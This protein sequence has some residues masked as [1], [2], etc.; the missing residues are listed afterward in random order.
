MAR[1]GSASKSANSIARLLHAGTNEHYEDAALYDFEY[2]DQREDVGWYRDR[3]RESSSQHPILELGAG[4]GRITIPL[5]EDGHAI[6]AVDRKKSMLARLRAKAS[7]PATDR[8][9]IIEA[10]ICD[11]PFDDHSMGMVIA[12]FNVMMHLYGWDQLLRCFEEVAR[13]L[14]PGGMF[15]FDVLLPD[16]EWLL[17]DPEFHH[18]RTRFIHPETKRPMVYSTNHTYDHETQVSHIRIHYHDAVGR[19]ARVRP[20]V[21]PRKTVHLAHRQIWPEELRCLLHLSGLQLDSLEGDF[22]G[23]RLTKNAESQVVVAHQPTAKRDKYTRL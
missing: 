12:P 9:E 20:E 23:D 2:G 8:L 18:C 6:V 10:D 22:D 17:L 14:R 19:G 21:P 15:C 5:L 11:L 3:A 1:G 4:T 13:V 7:S 16:F